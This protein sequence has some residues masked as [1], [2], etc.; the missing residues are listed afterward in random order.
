[1]TQ[2]LREQQDAA[3][4]ESLRADQEKERRKREESER[5][6][7]EELE[8]ERIIE[9]EIARKEVRF[10]ILMVKLNKYDV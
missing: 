7:Q 8:R 5:K 2:T 10:L 1:M 4:M 3:Y 9:E 6:R